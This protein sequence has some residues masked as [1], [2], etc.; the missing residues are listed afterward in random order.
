MR[1]EPSPAERA[2]WDALKGGQVEVRGRPIRFNRQQVIR[3]FIADLYVPR[4]R[5]IVEIDGD[6]HLEDNAAIYDERR[7]R[8]FRGWGY[9]ILRIR[10]RLVTNDAPMAR[11]IIRSFLEDVDEAS[12]TRWDSRPA[13][14][15][16]FAGNGVL[17]FHDPDG[18]RHAEH[19]FR[20]AD[21]TPESIRCWSGA[22]VGEVDWHPLGD[23]VE[24]CRPVRV[25]ARWRP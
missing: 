1:D 21:D 12:H 4:L 15:Y 23:C 13:L 8:A 3:G 9:S 7:D 19:Y 24:W 11:E 6:Q 22:E 16:R 17:A 14:L 25:S 5:A 10:A 2:I 18:R 20:V